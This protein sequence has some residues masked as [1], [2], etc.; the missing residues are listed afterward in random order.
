MKSAPTKRE[1]WQSPRYIVAMKCG[2]FRTTTQK[3]G[4]G[5][6]TPRSGKH[7][8]IFQKMLCAEMSLAPKNI[9]KIQIFF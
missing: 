6:K 9:C 2:R 7:S 3:R 5:G 1:A 4:C 8:A